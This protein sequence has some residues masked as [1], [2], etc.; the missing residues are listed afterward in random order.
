M[1]LEAGK[2]HHELYDVTG[3]ERLRA[4][5]NLFVEVHEQRRACFVVVEPNGVLHL[6][7]FN[8]WNSL[9]TRQRAIMH[10]E[11]VITR[12]AQGICEHSQRHPEA[13][14]PWKKAKGNEDEDVDEDV[15][16]YESEHGDITDAHVCI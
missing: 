16:E 11:P 13:L 6:D 12:I 7:P 2:I 10:M 8:I 9:S 14:H 4:V 1:A 5:Y 15:D 3:G